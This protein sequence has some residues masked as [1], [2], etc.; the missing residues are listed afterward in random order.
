[1]A[2]AGLKA[3]ATT[4][5]PT[6]QPEEAKTPTPL[7]S[8]LTPAVAV[9]NSSNESTPTA[10]GQLGTSIL[11]T[12][13]A[14]NGPS[15]A[16]DLPGGEEAGIHTPDVG[17]GRRVTGRDTPEREEWAVA[18]A[19]F[20]SNLSF[21]IEGPGR[22]SEEFDSDTDD[23]GEAKETRGGGQSVR[24]RYCNGEEINVLNV[25]GATPPNNLIH[26]IQLGSPLMQRPR[27]TSASTNLIP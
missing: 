15:A 21:A 22:V 13:T 27:K 17:N 18:L 1:M 24:A 16:K 4:D 23:G 6:T 11:A 7:D 14:V 3:S 25:C 12:A 5:T 8:G 20:S 26:D 19:L 9:R 2:E 10:K